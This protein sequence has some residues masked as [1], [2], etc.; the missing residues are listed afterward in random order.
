MSQVR[1]FLHIDA[2][3]PNVIIACAKV[4]IFRAL[5]DSLGIRTR[6]IKAFPYYQVH[7]M[8]RSDSDPMETR[9]VIPELD[10]PSEIYDRKLP[11]SCEFNPIR[12]EQH[13]ERG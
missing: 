5:H 7:S 12:R 10:I 6:L 3:A 8:Y 1:D 2:E 9:L 13:H 11:S 4:S